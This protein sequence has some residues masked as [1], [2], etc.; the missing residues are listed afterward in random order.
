VSVIQNALIELNAKLE[1]LEEVAASHEARAARIG[2]AAIVNGNG[3]SNGKHVIDSVMFAQKLDVAIERI[4][5][6][7]REG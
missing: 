6:V 3:K 7:L 1:S 4:E 5:Q 2:D